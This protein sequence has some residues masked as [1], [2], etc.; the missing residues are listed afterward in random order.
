MPDLEQITFIST[1]DDILDNITNKIHI[2]NGLYKWRFNFKF[3]TYDSEIFNM[4][5]TITCE[6]I[7]DH[8]FKKYQVEIEVHDLDTAEHTFSAN[9]HVHYGGGPPIFPILMIAVALVYNPIIWAFYKNS[10][11]DP[12]IYY[13]DVGFTSSIVY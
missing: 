10:W 8:Y 7:C 4:G 11:V 13:I 1:I 5:K 3:G 6:M 9:Q 2:L 12:P